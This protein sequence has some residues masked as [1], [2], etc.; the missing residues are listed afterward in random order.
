MIREYDLETSW[1]ASRFRSALRAGLNQSAGPDRAVTGDSKGGSL[2]LSL[3]RDLWLVLVPIVMSRSPS[4]E[5]ADDDLI[6]LSASS[7]LTAYEF[8]V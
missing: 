8:L 6:F 1:S 7:D 5:L 3:C 4:E 2:L